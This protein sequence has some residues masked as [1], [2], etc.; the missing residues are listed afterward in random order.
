MG[1]E[2]VPHHL[3][4]YRYLRIAGLALAR[5]DPATAGFPFEC[6]LAGPFYSRLFGG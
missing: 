1:S 6:G 2:A 3:R 5:E 4:W